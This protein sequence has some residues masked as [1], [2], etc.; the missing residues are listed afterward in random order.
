MQRP[1]DKLLAL[2]YL[3]H[4]RIATKE[5]KLPAIFS[6]F[7]CWTQGDLRSYEDTYSAGKM[8]TY[9]RALNLLDRCQ[10]FNTELVVHFH[11]QDKQRHIPLYRKKD[12]LNEYHR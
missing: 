7:V 6:N 2:S 11:R 4:V 3:W 8:T 12:S 1:E 10:C 5:D 9:P